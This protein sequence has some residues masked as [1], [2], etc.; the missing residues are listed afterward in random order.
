[1][2]D[3]AGA[4]PAAG[5]FRFVQFEFPW[6]LGPA[7]GRYVLRDAGDDAA[8]RIVVL[9]ELGAPE[10]RLV[11]R[12]RRRARAVEPEP[13]PAAVRT[14]RATIIRGVPVGEAE[15]AEWL[16]DAGERVPEELAV[17]RRVV[18]LHRLSAADHGVREPALDQ[19]LAVRVGYGSGDEVADGRW[20]EA[21]EPGEP[22]E[23]VKREAALRPQ[24]RLAALL[25][26]RDAALACEELALRA[27]ADLDGGRLREAA[28]QL[29][30]ALDAAIAEL[31]A[32]R[33]RRDLGERLAELRE[34]RPAVQRAAEAA[35]RGGLDDASADEVER[36][37]G[38][39]E[40]ALRAR[41]AYGID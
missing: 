22:R 39:L 21:V 19:A 14:T 33:D 10:M 4:Q 17:L 31:E 27:R 8:L 5:L 26:G 28:L 38:R 16:K 1:V 32:W 37:T 23:R 18:H 15:A 36:V 3:P 34:A 35:L 30:P 25:G 20:T 24:E 11:P 9:K 7:D 6:L 29:A 41:T 40:A 12:R 2:S 13:A